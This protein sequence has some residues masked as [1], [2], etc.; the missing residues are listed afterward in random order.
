MSRPH[1]HV[2]KLDDETVRVALSG[3]PSDL[4]G[5]LAGAITSVSERLNEEP[6]E[7][8]SIVMKGLNYMAEEQKEEEMKKKAEAK[9]PAPKKPAPKKAAPKKGKKK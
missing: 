6:K 2:V 9:K 4:L 1:I 3:E 5:L 7:I 8:V